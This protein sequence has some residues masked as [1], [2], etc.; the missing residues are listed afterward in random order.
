MQ[1][2]IA[3][4]S[5][6]NLFP[7]AA[8]GVVVARGMKSA[9]DVSPEKAAM[10]SQLLAAANGMAETH[11]TSEVISENDVVR[12][13]RD[14]YRSFKTKKGA[15][16]SI[17]NLL[18]RVLKGNPVRSINPSVD[19]YNAISLKYALPVGG[20]D[21]DA[22]AGDVRLG[23]TEGG[24]PFLPLGEN[25]EDPTLPGEL[26]YLDDA[27]AICRCWNWR[28]G[29]RS[30]LSDDSKNAFLV[31][32]CVDPARLDDLK[33]ALDEL[34]SLVESYLDATVERKAVITRENPS[35]TIAD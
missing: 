22:F 12:V 9:A 18:K 13:W 30:A 5:F 35:L 6:W 20:E 11:L 1:K 3:E 21:I 17:E 16:C 14:A 7:D 2:F 4:E 10:P 25:D 31:I 33:A 32:E 28:D 27:G 23:L 29:Q 34:A 24:D 19:I 26:C 8:I 15:R